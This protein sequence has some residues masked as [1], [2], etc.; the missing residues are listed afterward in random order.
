MSYGEYRTFKPGIIRRKS[1]EYS[2]IILPDDTLEI[3]DYHG[4]SKDI[5]IPSV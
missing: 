3:F 2:Y 1:K 4:T 5:V